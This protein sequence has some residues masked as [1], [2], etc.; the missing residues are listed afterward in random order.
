MSSDSS[1]LLLHSVYSK[2]DVSIP[3]EIASGQCQEGGDAGKIVRNDGTSYRPIFPRQEFD[4]II[5]Y[6]SDRTVPELF[7][8][9]SA[10]PVAEGENR[11]GDILIP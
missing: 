11:Q 10:S 1:H 9:E 8:N 5:S 2:R 3:I 6:A 4:S 7:H